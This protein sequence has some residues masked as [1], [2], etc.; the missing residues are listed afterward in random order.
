MKRITFLLLLL[1]AFSFGQATDSQ[2]S[3]VKRNV[4][5]GSVNYQSQLHYLG[6]V[7]SF[8][9]SGLFPI[10]GYEFR[11]GIYAQAS[12]V[13][14]NNNSQSLN[15]TGGS[16]E[17]GYKF[18]EREHFEGNVFVSKFFYSDQSILVQ[19]ALQAQTGIN[20]TY[21]NNVLNINGGADLK[22]SDQ[23]DLGATFSVDHLF[24][25]PVKEWRKSAVAIMPSATLHAGTQ[26]F[27]TTH[28]RK[29]NFL[30]LPVT[31]QKMEQTNK[32]NILAYE[33]SAPVVLVAGSF[34]AYLIP[35]YI[36]PQN[37]VVDEKGQNLL[38]VT[39]GLG[40]RL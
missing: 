19:S 1:P 9:S 10:L 12:A 25:S 3:I 22:F 37:L 5:T 17:A 35:S 4:F 11:N 33:F 40:L 23:T 32:F 28:I 2:D 18:P 13:F 16:I 38:Y 30:G 34:N 6:R 7:D 31:Q 24:V 36:I 8:R 27:T 21:K 39:A 15:Y 20:L 29:S 14:V 26:R